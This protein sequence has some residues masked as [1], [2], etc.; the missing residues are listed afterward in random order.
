MEDVYI[1]CKT[2]D[3]FYKTFQTYLKENESGEKEVEECWYMW[4]IT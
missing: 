3:N 4:L 1:M 2:N